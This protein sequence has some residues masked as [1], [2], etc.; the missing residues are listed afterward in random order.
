MGRYKKRRDIGA[1]ATKKEKE[2]REHMYESMY[3][4]N[5]TCGSVPEQPQELLDQLVLCLELGFALRELCLHLCLGLE[6]V[7]QLHLALF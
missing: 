3:F 4:V 2:G 7:I 1:Q 6:H 5:S